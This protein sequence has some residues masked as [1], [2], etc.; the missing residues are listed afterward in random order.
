MSSKPR[1]GGYEF[2]GRSFFSVQLYYANAFGSRLSKTALPGE[3]NG[4]ALKNVTQ[5]LT[6][7]NKK[8]WKIVRSGSKISLLLKV[9]D[10]TDLGQKVSELKLEHKLNLIWNCDET[11][12]Q[13]Q[14]NQVKVI[15]QKGVKNVVSMVSENRTNITI[16]ACVNGAGK[17][18]SQWSLLRGKLLH[19]FMV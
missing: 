19:P 13:F 5:S 8:N 9:H 1:R 18:W 3:G 10:M 2:Q 6:S 11:G 15:V 17:R 16:M 12:K 7:E 4:I 14:Y